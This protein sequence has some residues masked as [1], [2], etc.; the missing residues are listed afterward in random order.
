MM[1]K[2]T[3]S[4]KPRLEPLEDRLCL[5]S[6]A[7]VDLPPPSGWFSS[8]AN[9][10]NDVGWIA[11]DGADQQSFIS[12]ALWRRDNAGNVVTTALPEVVS[13]ASRAS[14]INR[15]GQVVG[16]SDTTLNGPDP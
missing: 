15:L 6:Y 8:S 13:R 14:D 9:A 7:I 4:F 10:V 12:A 16:F 11:G 5:S 1:R 3:S 2:R